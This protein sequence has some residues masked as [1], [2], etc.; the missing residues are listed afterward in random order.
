M[1]ITCIGA[2]ISNN[3]VSCSEN[4]ISNLKSD[5]PK[6]L[7]KGA[8]KAGLTN[9]TGDDVVISAIVNDEDLPLINKEIV[10]I[11]RDNAEDIGD[12]GGVGKTSEEAGEG[13]SY[14]TANIREDRFPDAVILHFDTYG[15]ES[16]VAHVAESAIQ[17]AKGI[18]S[19]TDVSILNSE[20]INEIPGVGYVGNETDD[21]VIVATVEDL[22]QIGVISG[23]M[24][25]ASLGCK[26]TYLVKRHTP[27][28][29]IPGSVLVSATAFTNGNIIDLAVPFE[30]KTRILK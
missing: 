1:K 17:A 6:L 20:D 14:A 19:C 13:I 30:N 3:D 7:K 16:F 23:A 21:P 5:I 11:L 10:N 24:I 4:L 12:I 25:G 9:I 2:D 15:G 18:S 29:V 26:N 27:C 8:I 22:E 28:N